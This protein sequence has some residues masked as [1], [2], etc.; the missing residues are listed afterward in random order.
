MDIPA[1]KQAANYLET[2]A[3]RNSPPG[4]HDTTQRLERCREFFSRLGNPQNGFQFIHIAGTSGKGSIAKKIHTALHLAG[5]R[6]GLFCSPYT[7]TP[8]EKIAVDDLYIAA[9]DFARLVEKI[10]PTIEAMSNSDIGRPLWN[11]MYLALAL[12][13]FQEQGVEYAIIET[14]VGGRHDATNI[15]PTPKVTIISSIAFDHQEL[16]GDTLREIAWHKAG[17]IKPGTHFLTIDSH[18]E[19]VVDE[20]QKACDQASVTYT[21]VPT[22]LHDSLPIYIQ[23]NN[24]VVRRTCELLQADTH[25]ATALETAALPCRFETIAQHP[26]IIIDG[27]HNQAKIQ[28]TLDSL[29]KVGY[30]KLYLIVGCTASKDAH[31]LFNTISGLSEYIYITATPHHRKS[32]PAK[33]LA[34]QLDLALEKHSIYSNPFDALNAALATAGADDCIVITGSLYLAG[35]LRTHWR[36]EQIILQERKS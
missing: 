10:K 32:M 6:T 24:A 8:I 17:I 3:Q 9:D 34:T 13:Y 16:L 4:I 31:T 2:V 33:T 18:P 22:E 28:A 36:S 23:Q 12:L 26:R 19:E 7:T 5:K 21:E 35:L 20:L 1:Y 14:G 11:E 29:T 15:I 25:V 30:N 27:A